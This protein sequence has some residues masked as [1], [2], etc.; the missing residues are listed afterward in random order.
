MILC[1]VML[2][3]CLRTVDGHFAVDSCDNSEDLFAA[4]MGGLKQQNNMSK[5]V[6][7]IKRDLLRAVSHSSYC[8]EGFVFAGPTTSAE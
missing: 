5:I 8:V 3:Y 7:N 4:G 6:A 2:G 1:R